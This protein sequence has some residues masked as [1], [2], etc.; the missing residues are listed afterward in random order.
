MSSVSARIN[1]LSCQ[2]V[3]YCFIVV[4]MLDDITAARDEEDGTV[5]IT[6]QYRGGDIEIVVSEWGFPV[7]VSVSEDLRSW[8]AD[9]VAAAVL[10]VY[11]KAR[12]KAMDAQF[13]SSL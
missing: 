3:E 8:G 1:G 2:N 9:D 4:T 10:V 5:F 11:K 7:L 13:V 12:L 6:A